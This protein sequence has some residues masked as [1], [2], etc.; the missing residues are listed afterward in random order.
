MTTPNP[1]PLAA[2]ADPPD[3][4]PRPDGRVY[5]EGGCVDLV[6]EASEDSFPCSDPPGWVGRGETRVAVSAVT[7]P[8]GEA[9]MTRDQVEPFRRRLRELAA[10]LD[11]TVAGLEDQAR[12]PTGGES[13]GGIS[14]TPMHLG[15]VGSE[16]YNQELGATL[17]ENE[18]YL[19]GEVADALGR[20]DAGT[21]GR[22]EHCGRAVH[23]ERL[24]ALPYARHCTAC[25][26]ALQSG[27]PVNLNDGRPPTF[28][29]TPGHEAADVTGSPGRR[30]GRDVGGAPGDVHAA[31]TPGGGTEVGGLAG[32]NVGSGAPAGVAL[33]EA[34]GRGDADADAAADDD[35]H[36][37]ESGSGGG[38][39]GGTPAN[40]RAKRGGSGGRKKPKG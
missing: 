20:I 15:D 29:G 6:Q 19:R 8:G 17:L 36:G 30:V 32:T 23:P 25:A 16:A 11:G 28:L 5:C 39:V 40:K 7:L 14:N 2:V 22:C 24:D 10:R 9:T 4:T 37:A 33:E 13:A 21:Y 12:T 34:M 35:D 27:R 26:A 3:G 31:G 38:A 18:T 1:R